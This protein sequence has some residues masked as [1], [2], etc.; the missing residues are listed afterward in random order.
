MSRL[1]VGAALVV[2]VLAAT[3]AEAQ[4]L[5]PRTYANAPVGLNFLILGYAY[6]RGD[7]AFDASTP[8]ENAEL[9][10]HSPFLAYAR[11]LDVWGRAG[12][13]DV[14]LPFA[15]LS[16]TAT[17]AGQPRERDIAGLGDPRIRFSVLLH[18]APALSLAEFSGYT[19]DL[20][21]GASLAVTIPLGQYDADK[22]VNVGTNRW[23]VKPELGVS[24]TLGPFTLELSGSVTF[25]TDNNDFLGGRTLEKDPLY[26]V[27]AHGIYQTRWGV[28]AAVDVT[29]YIGGRTTIDGERAERPENLRVGLT[30]AI[31]INRH[32]SLKLYGSTGAMARVGGEFDTVGIAWQYRWGG[33]L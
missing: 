32:N 3:T 21:V 27:Q 25:Y 18:G 16:G 10:A 15:A 22:L 14:V 30:V 19:P 6:T 17:F 1:G 8:I 13:L 31:P 5:E 23:S 12:K 2:V 24:K 29:Y 9:E 20:I 26:A 28:W 7:V 33:G 11:A 4:D